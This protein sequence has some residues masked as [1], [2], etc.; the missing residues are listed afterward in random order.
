MLTSAESEYIRGLISVY[1]SKGYQYYMCH[2]V[3][4]NNNNYDVC[5]YFSKEEIKAIDNN[6]YSISN[7]IRIYVDSSSRTYNYQTGYSDTPR[8]LLY[9]FNG[10]VTV[11]IAEFIYTNAIVDY[12]LSSYVVNPDI[13]MSA[14]TNYSINKIDVTLLCLIV[15]I[16]LFSFIR[17]IF[18][19]K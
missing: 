1:Q 14:A 16:L 19:I 2:T 6:I 8:T 12:S 9:N 17:S 13:M 5:I 3:T 10:T 11:N 7:G 4:E 15:I 18:R